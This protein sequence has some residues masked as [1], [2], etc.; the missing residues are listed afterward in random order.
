MDARWHRQSNWTDFRSP[1]C[2]LDITTARYSC[3]PHPSPGA[4]GFTPRIIVLSLGILRPVQSETIAHE[5]IPQ[6]GAAHRACRHSATVSVQ[7]YWQAIYRPPCD[8]GV[9]IVRRLCT[10]PI[11]Q[12]ILA[13]TKLATFRGIDSPKAN[14]RSVDFKRVAIDDAGLPR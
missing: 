11:R 5:P 4:F 10:A 7:R 2:I 12:A 9:Q 8:E 1:E 6:V 14:A 13:A 3:C